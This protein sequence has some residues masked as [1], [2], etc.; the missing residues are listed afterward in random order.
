MQSYI[1]LGAQISN[2]KSSIENQ[3]FTGKSPPWGQDGPGLRLNYLRI[4]KLPHST[5]KPPMS[6]KLL[7]IR[8][9]LAISH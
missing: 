2:F 1:T 3:N 6:D 9:K 7:F 5:T 8:Q 4:H